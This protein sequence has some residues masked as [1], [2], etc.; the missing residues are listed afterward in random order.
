[1][2]KKSLLSFL[3]LYTYTPHTAN[4]HRTQT[5][6]CSALN[7]IHAHSWVSHPSHQYKADSD[8]YLRKQVRKKLFLAHSFVV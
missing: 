2:S 7:C 3:L 6:F 8:A 1:M 4:Q 5:P